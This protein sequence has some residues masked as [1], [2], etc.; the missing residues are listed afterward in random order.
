MCCGDIFYE[1]CKYDS[2]CCGGLECARLGDGRGRQCLEPMIRQI[3]T[4]IPTMSPTTCSKV[5]ERC[6]RD[7]DCCYEELFCQGRGKR[8]KCRLPCGEIGDLCIEDSNCCRGFEC[9]RRECVMTTQFPTRFP[10]ITYVDT[11]LILNCRYRVR[12]SRF[13]AFLPLSPAALR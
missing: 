11:A 4:V 12:L 3:D 13:F 6:E 2:D 1:G 10:T 5:D 8:K 9:D 7:A